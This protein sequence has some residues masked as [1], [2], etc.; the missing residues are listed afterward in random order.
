MF[1]KIIKKLFG[2]KI[3]FVLIYYDFYITDSIGKI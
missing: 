3:L 1:R 2:L